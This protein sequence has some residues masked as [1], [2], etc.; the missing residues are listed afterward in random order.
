MCLKVMGQVENDMVLGTSAYKNGVRA[1]M[2]AFADKG[3]F[4]FAGE[5]EAPRIVR[6]F[7]LD[8]PAAEK[9]AARA[10]AIR[11]S[12][13]GRWP[14]TPWARPRRHRPGVRPAGRP[15]RRGHRA[16]ALVRRR[17]H[18]AGRA[19]A[20]R[21]PGVGATSSPTPAPPSSPPRSS[22]TASAPARSGAP[23]TTASGANR[24]GITRDDLT[25][26]ITERNQKTGSGHARLTARRAA[27]PS[28]RTPL[29]L[30]PPLAPHTSPWPAN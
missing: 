13:P 3:I 5:G 15:R 11:G 21:L 19:A 23:P 2:F 27:R 16:Q 17:R 28:T 18:P 29:D 7:Y 6:G 4:Y 10:R 8:A 26:A 20:R 1:T 12:G 9:I 24:R 14:G 30:A 25:K 22:P